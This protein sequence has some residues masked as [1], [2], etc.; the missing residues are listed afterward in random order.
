VVAVVGDPILERRARYARWAEVG[1][2]VG[3]G[4]LVV[5]VVAFVVAVA[6]GFP[7]PSVAIVIAGLVGATV[8]LPPAIVFGYAVKAAER[9]D[10]ELMAR[11]QREDPDPGPR[12]GG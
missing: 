12:T 5:A 8:A 11:R 4:C 10:R 7:G 2:R 9:E 1:R 3:Y 6:A